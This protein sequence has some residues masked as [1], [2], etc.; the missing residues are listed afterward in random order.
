MSRK[1]TRGIVVCPHNGGGCSWEKE[2]DVVLCEPRWKTSMMKMKTDMQVVT[3]M[4]MMMA[5]AT[6]R[7]TEYLLCARSGVTTLLG[8]P[9]LSL[10]S[11]EHIKM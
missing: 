2:E 4:V 6:I 10:F 9:L 11:S 5:A 3:M 8:T 7:S 1:R